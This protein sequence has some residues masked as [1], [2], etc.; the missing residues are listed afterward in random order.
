MSDTFKLPEWFLDE[1][2]AACTRHDMLGD[3]EALRMALW[4]VCKLLDADPRAAKFKLLF[5]QLGTGLHDL[6]EGSRPRI[7]EPKIWE[8]GSG[9]RPPSFNDDAIPAYAAATLGILRKIGEPL[10]P[11]A[12]KVAATLTKF[13]FDLGGRQAV[14]AEKVMNWRKDFNSGRRNARSTKIYRDFLSEHREADQAW[15]LAIERKASTRA[16]AV[17]AV[18]AGLDWVLRNTSTKSEKTPPNISP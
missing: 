1:L 4:S 6:D 18:L 17:K 9:P 3:R 11:A 15:I 13:D 8:P 2:A 10:K 16:K 14:S 7:F 5:L 12:S